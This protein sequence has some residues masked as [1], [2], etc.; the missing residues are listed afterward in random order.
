MENIYFRRATFWD[1]EEIRELLIKS[2]WFTY[3]K[4][5]STAYIERL[6][7]QYYNLERIMEEVR[8][9]TARWHGY[10][11]AEMDRRIVGVVGG[12]MIGEMAAEVYV[13]YMD[14]Q[15]RGKGIGTRLLNFFTKIQKYTY[16][17]DEQ[18]VAVA[19]GNQYGI[20]FYEARGFQFQNESALFDGDFEED[21]KMTLR[22]RRKI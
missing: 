4:L 3:E 8:T 13:L 10:Y 16:G 15:L 17:A 2:Q 6:I 12:G 11:V 21:V 14:P 7:E 18:W 22:Y 5:F 19:K 9:E 20:P 1:A